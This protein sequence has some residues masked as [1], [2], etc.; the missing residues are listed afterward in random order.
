M[1][2]PS[3]HAAV[4]EART[5]FANR[6]TPVADAQHVLVSGINSRKIG[7]RVTKGHWRGMPVFTLTLEERATCPTSCAHWRDCFGNRMSWALRVEH[8]PALESR[9]DVEFAELQRRHP[10]G[11]VVRLHVLGDFYSVAY[12]ARWAGW[13]SRYPAIR[14]F[15]YTAHAPDS[16]IGSAI[17]AM[18]DWDRCAIRFSGTGGARGTATIDHLRDATKMV[19]AIVC[20][21]QTGK[22]ECCSSC[23]LCWAPAAQHRAIAF[24]AH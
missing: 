20:P 18:N 23:A 2:L 22:T 10:G 4:R 9:L 1:S 3:A 5:L 13:L 16:A 6:R 11:F 21:A 15:G 14:V 8:G 24:I 17:A 7:K 12:V 19:G